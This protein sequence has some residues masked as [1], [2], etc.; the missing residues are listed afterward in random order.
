MDFTLADNFTWSTGR[1][2]SGQV[3]FSIFSHSWTSD[4]LA[5]LAIQHPEHEQDQQRKHPHDNNLWPPATESADPDPADHRSAVWALAA[6]WTL[7]G[8]PAVTALHRL[9]T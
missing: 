3:S 6:Q 8:S 2:V 1:A 9:V 5:D 4:S 7:E